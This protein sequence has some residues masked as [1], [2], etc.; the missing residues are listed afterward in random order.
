MLTH[1]VDFVISHFVVVGGKRNVE[2]L[3]AAGSVVVGGVAVASQDPL[4]GQETFDSNG[5]SSVNAAS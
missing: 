2:E 3:L 1:F 4:G 5:T